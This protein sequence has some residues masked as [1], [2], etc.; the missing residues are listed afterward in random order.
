MDNIWVFPGLG[1]QS[2]QDVGYGE[3]RGPCPRECTIIP[4]VAFVWETITD[5]TE[6]SFLHVLF[7]RVEGLVLRD[8][9]KMILVPLTRYGHSSDQSFVMVQRTSSLA[10]VHLG[11]STT[12]FNTVC[13]SLAYRGTSWKGETGVPSFSTKARNSRVLGAPNL[14]TLN[15]GGCLPYDILSG[16]GDEDDSCRK[17]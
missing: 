11:I 1:D 12:I 8:L 6:L 17:I 2:Q 10:L 3:Q 16:D 15:S 9:M 5:E 14:R 13:C 7:D 4:E